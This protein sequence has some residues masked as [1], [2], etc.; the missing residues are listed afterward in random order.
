ME[1]QRDAAT[2]ALGFVDGHHQFERGARVG[3][4]GQRLALLFDGG[5]QVAHERA[6]PPG[7]Y[8]FI[9]WRRLVRNDARPLVAEARENYGPRVVV[10][11]PVAD[12][13]QRD[14]A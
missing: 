10:D 1:R 12:A 3:A 13:A 11:V 2:R 7:V 8:R 14:E 9:G 5:E 4:A 6:V